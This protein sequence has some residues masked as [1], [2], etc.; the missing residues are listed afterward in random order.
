[1][2]SCWNRSP[3]SVTSGRTFSTQQQTRAR[4]IPELSN[5]FQQYTVTMRRPTNFDYRIVHA[6]ME[7]AGTSWAWERLHGMIAS[8]LWRLV[9]LMVAYAPDEGLLG[10]VAAGPVEDLM[11]GE[12]MK[13]LMRREAEM[14]PRFRIC[15][16]MTNGM[17]KE[18]EAFEDRET[19][20]ET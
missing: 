9:Q 16:G 5:D 13:P 19:R 1:M 8:D 3:L 2:T 12:S 7:N 10:S 6:W 15:L 4:T 17:P 14:N 20:L 11:V 18:L